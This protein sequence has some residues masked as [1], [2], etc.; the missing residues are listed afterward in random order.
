MKRLD[1]TTEKLI[2]GFGKMQEI[3]NGGIKN[4]KKKSEV[5]K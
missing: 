4:Y 3:F 1:K 2:I 5:R